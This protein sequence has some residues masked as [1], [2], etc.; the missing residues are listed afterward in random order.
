MDAASLEHVGYDADLQM[1]RQPSKLNV[2]RL[3]FQR[4]LVDRGLAEHE[5]ASEVCGELIFVAAD[6]TVANPCARRAWIPA[7]WSAPTC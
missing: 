5:A 6:F 3:L 7:D 1:H 2:G 4:W